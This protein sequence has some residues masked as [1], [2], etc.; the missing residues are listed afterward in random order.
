MDQSDLLRFLVAALEEE[1]IPYMLVGSFASMA[2]G[3]P[4]LTRDIDV[5]VDLG[6][7][8]VSGLCTRFPPP[9]YYLDPS[10]VD[11]AV[12]S[13]R[14]FNAIHVASGTRIDFLPRRLDEWGTEE[15]SRRE[16]VALLPDCRGY[17]ARPEDVVIGKLLYFHEGGSEKHVRDIAGVL[18]ISAD[19]VDAAYIARWAKRLGVD[20][21]WEAICRRLG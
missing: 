8:Q 21:V 11:D 13:R 20:E 19:R 15:F 16:R 7:E 9:N 6:P 2:Y 1:R 17:T 4:R 5:V 14:P 3:E 18:Q 12:R 10:S